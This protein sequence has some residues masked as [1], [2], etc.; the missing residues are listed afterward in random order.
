MAA[1]PARPDLRVPLPPASGPV[2]ALRFGLTGLRVPDFRRARRRTVRWAVPVLPALL[3]G[4]PGLVIAAA[5]TLYV[6]LRIAALGWTERAQEQFVPEWL[7]QRSEALRRRSFEVVRCSVQVDRG[8][9]PVDLTS[10]AEVRRLL[11]LRDTEDCAAVV[12]LEFLYVPWPGAR[13]AVEHV[14]RPLTDL[15]VAAVLDAWTPAR[16]GFPAARYLPT[17][18]G[19]RTSWL[20]TGPIQV[21]V[22]AV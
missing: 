4:R 11:R 17:P 19:L 6:L 2:A 10:P 3:L 15:G 9:R 7:A 18:D 21:T 20:L 12:T 22:A 14:R 8:A 16:V 13:P 5:L 1:E